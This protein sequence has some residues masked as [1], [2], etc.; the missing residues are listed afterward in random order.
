MCKFESSQKDESRGQS[1]DS[2]KAC[3]KPRVFNWTTC[4]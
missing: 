3:R 2:L 4:I 1:T